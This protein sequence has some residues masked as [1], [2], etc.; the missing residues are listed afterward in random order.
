MTD[1]AWAAFSAAREDYRAAVARIAEALPSLRAAQQ[2]LVDE[3]EGGSFPVETPVVYNGALDDVRA[4]DDIGIILVADNPGRREQAAENR[5]YLVGPSGKLADGFFK[6]HPGL[7]VDFRR[8]VVILNKTPIHTP[9]T[10]ELRELGRIGGQDIE[11][12]IADTQADMV[13]LIRSFHRA[14]NIGRSEPVQLWIIGYSEMGKRKLFEPFTRELDAAYRNSGDG[15]G[16]GSDV[17]RASVLL[18]RHFS[19]NQFSVDIRKRA[20]P[21]ESVGETLRR[22]GAEYRSRVLGW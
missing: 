8:N 3:R 21:Q 18:F 17:L 13:R 6:A 15:D 2:R 12:A 22:V 19:M 14:V 4:E 10:A 7:G 9:R 20:L 11:R 16:F 5:R 1:A